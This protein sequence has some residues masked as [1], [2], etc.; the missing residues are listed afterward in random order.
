LECEKCSVHFNKTK[1]GVKL[2][3]RATKNKLTSR[4]GKKQNRHVSSSGCFVEVEDPD[5][6][7]ETDS[8]TGDKKIAVKEIR[9]E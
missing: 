5:I 8:K 3:S 9:M 4:G 7:S 6:C 1:N 2:F